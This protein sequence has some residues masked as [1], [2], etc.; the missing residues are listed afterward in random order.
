ML[1]GSN[2]DK[3]TLIDD[4]TVSFC[5]IIYTL[6]VG[7]GSRKKTIE[8]HATTSRT[9]QKVAFYYLIVIYAKSMLSDLN[10]TR[11][12]KASLHP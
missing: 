5:A 1:S 11:E 2:T 9:E 6:T 3:Q 12:F 7:T 10:T 8:T 4:E